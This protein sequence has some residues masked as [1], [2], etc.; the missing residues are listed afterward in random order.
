MFTER[1]I[2]LARRKERLSSRAQSQR[3]AVAAA[4]YGLE[5]PM[6]ALD[7]GVDAARYLRGHPLLLA[8]SAAVVVIAS[9]HGLIRWAGRGMLVWRLWRSVRRWAGLVAA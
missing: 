7:R 8:A 6:A 1:R 5:Q 3:I 9:R 2:D 4:F